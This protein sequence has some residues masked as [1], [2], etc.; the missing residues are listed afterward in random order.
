MRLESF[1]AL[2]TELRARG[3]YR[4]PTAR[5]LGEL[6]LFLV[7]AA[8]GLVMFTGLPSLSL[9]LL[10]L[11]LLTWSSFALAANTHTSSH[12]AT[13]DRRWLNELLTYF[14]YPLFLQFSA[15]YWWHKHLRVHH[16]TPNVIGV[17]ADVDFRPVFTLDRDELD[18]CSPG[19]RRYYRYQWVIVPLALAGNA[20]SM[21]F[22]GWR[23]L[24]RRL[25]QRRLRRPA[26]WIDL[27]AMTLHWVF[28]VLVPL[29]FFAPVDVVLFHLLRN[30]LLSYVAFA[31]FAPAHL[32][33][34]ALFLQG[35][36]GAGDFLL[37]QTL[38]TVNFRTGRLGGLLCAGLQYQIEHHLFPGISHVFYP[39][40]SKLVKAY[41]ETHGYPYRTLGWGEALWKA[42]MVFYRPKPVQ[43]LE[44]V[45]PPSRATLS[46]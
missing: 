4:R 44:A 6:L 43:R 18:Q 35:E 20:F 33:A 30:G 14:G 41:C 23:Y 31:A 45:C 34:E 9:R 26:H 15:T 29:W 16:R 13:S 10:G 5:I 7:I 36:G 3:Y 46:A 2:H 1:G 27:G 17:D 32:P 28:W 11:L 24:I 37:R 38:T 12:Y 42:L 19:K 40:A 22:A 39:E 25:R 21:Q 8:I